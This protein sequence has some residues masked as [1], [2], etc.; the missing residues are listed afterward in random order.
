MLHAKGISY[1]TENGFLLTIELLLEKGVKPDSE[2]TSG[3]T[4]LSWAAKS[5]RLGVVKRLMKGSVNPDSKT[6][7]GQTPLSHAA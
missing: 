3:R 5:G 1:A 4:P 7:N 2:D 6:H